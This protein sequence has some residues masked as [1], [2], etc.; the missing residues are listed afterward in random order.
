MVNYSKLALA[1]IIAAIFYLSCSSEAPLLPQQQNLSNQKYNHSGIVLWGFYDVYIDIPTQTVEVIVNRQAMFTANVVNFINGNAANLSFKIN[2]TPVGADWVDVD[3]DVTIKHPFPGLPQYNGYD[4]RGVFMGNGSKSLNYNSDLI[5]AVSGNDQ[6]MLPDP[7]DGFGGPDGYTRWFNFPEFSSGG[8]PLFQYTKGKLATPGYNSSATINPYK[9]FADNLGA[10][11]NLWEWLKTHGNSHG[12]FSSGFSNTRNYYLR[13]PNSVGVK[14]NYAIIAN[15][16]GT[17]KKYHPSNT[18][19]AVAVK[20]VDSSN[21]YFVSPTDKGGKIR[22]DVSIWDWDSQVSGGVMDDYRIFL[23]SSVLQNVYEFSASDMIPVGGDSSYSTYHVEIVPDN[24]NSLYGNEY[25]LIVEQKGYDYAN[26][27]GVSN[28]A[29]KDTLAAFFRYPHNI[30]PEATNH[31][32][33]C[34]LKVV[35][36]LPV[37]GWD[38]GTPVAFDASGSTDPDGDP[39]TFQWDFDGDGVFSE[40]VDDSYKGNPDKPTREY[41]A[42]Y[43]GKVSVRVSDNNGGSSECSVNVQVVVHQS[44]NILLRSGV[45]ARDIGV[46]PTNGILHILYSDGQVW[47]YF[48][49]QWY[50]QAGASLFYSTLTQYDRIDVHPNGSTA[51]CGGSPSMGHRHF[52]PS[53]VMIGL[54]NIGYASILRDVSFFPGTGSN[55]GDSCFIFKDTGNNGI[56]YRYHDPGFSTFTQHVLFQSSPYTGIYKFYSDWVTGI[57]CITNESV[58]VVETTDY[59]ATR[60]KVTDTSPYFNI[61]YDNSY[62]GTGSQ[63]DANNGFNDPR[64]LTADVN[65]RIF[66]LDRLSDNSPRIKVYQPTG[67]PA[68]FIGAFGNTTNISGAPL[69]IEG[70]DFV[71]PVYGNMIFVLHGAAPP[72]M[73]SIFFPSEIP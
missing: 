45:T 54:W 52:D 25:W 67:E 31:N 7:D 28:L 48:P 64:D 8:M 24:L 6:F 40:P 70:S 1:C 16:E 50:T 9:Y 4:V 29:D 53:G 37:H 20:V 72:Q 51:V 38:V 3:I 14:Y 66:I 69:R 68:G 59:Y 60:F 12:V 35:S 65:K 57:E 10:V 42:N 34:D 23:E 47:K 73:I 63:T 15:W 11:E 17:E 46:N 49:S 22:L 32:P 19:E 2:D 36:T 56:F 26:N 27:F 55:G 33:I 21:L 30:S 43:N 13:F 58:W 71:D 41:K 62:I 44:K 39:L 18:S 61:V 5:Y